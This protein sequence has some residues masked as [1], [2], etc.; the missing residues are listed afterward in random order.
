MLE[1]ICF[2]VWQETST[3]IA[4]RDMAESCDLRGRIEKQGFTLWTS[5]SSSEF[6]L[7]LVFLLGLRLLPFIYQGLICTSSW[8]GPHL[9]AHLVFTVHL[10]VHEDL[11]V[12]G[13]G[14]SA[15]ISV[16]FLPVPWPKHLQMLASSASS[17]PGTLDGDTFHF[18]SSMFS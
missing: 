15:A 10:A 2:S 17:F 9:H 4:C 13:S 7:W 6:N 5:V 8:F 11:S 3:V 14:S 18:S 1:N 16:L 12:D